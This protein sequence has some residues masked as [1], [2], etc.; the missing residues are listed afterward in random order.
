MEHCSLK[1]ESFLDVEALKSLISMISE[2]KIGCQSFV[3]FPENKPDTVL[4]IVNFSK[5]PNYELDP[6]Y[7]FL[8]Y[9]WD[10]RHANNPFLPKIYDTISFQV[11]REGK[12]D[13]VFCALRME[14]LHDPL[15]KENLEIFLDLMVDGIGFPEVYFSDIKELETEDEFNAYNRL[16]F[17]E[18]GQSGE[19]SFALDMCYLE[20]RDKLF[21]GLKDRSFVQTFLDIESHIVESGS[22]FNADAKFENFLIRKEDGENHIVLVDPVNP[23]VVKSETERGVFDKYNWKKDIDQNSVGMDCLLNPESP[24]YQHLR[25]H[26][27]FNCRR[28]SH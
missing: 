25:L 12:R 18:E 7:L 8:N 13:L 2:S 27:L 15:R 4:K 21:K 6:L 1:E 10:N 23:I 5:S 22:D 19:E 17:W 28:F 20:D 3:W 26:E 9:V 11:V 14:R 24:V 16:P